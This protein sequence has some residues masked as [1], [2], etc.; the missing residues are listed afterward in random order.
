M[1]LCPFCIIDDIY[2]IKR[3]K[4]YTINNYWIAHTVSWFTWTYGECSHSYYL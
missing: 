4:Q 3:G 2:A 1:I